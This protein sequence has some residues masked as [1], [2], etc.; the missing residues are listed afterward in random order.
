MKQILKFSLLAI[1]PVLSHADSGSGHPLHAELQS[2]R[3]EVSALTARVELLEKQ[4]DSGV[5]VAP[6]KESD[7]G[8]LDRLTSAMQ[9]RTIATHYPW[10]DASLWKKI[11]TGMS[12]EAVMAI[13]G[14]PSMT[15]PSL[16]K[17][18]DTVYTYKGR[19]PGTGKKMTGKVKFYRGLVVK[20]EAPQ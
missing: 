7:N 4:V 19:H 5:S 6:A 17:R 18:I 12:P 11:D 8:I 16:H 10:M 1:L 13:L 15:D 2:L 20:I 14:E 3:D 9:D